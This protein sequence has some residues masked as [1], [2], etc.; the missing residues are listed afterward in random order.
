MY[1]VMLLRGFLL[2]K[3]YLNDGTIFEKRF[4]CVVLV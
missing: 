1:L 4:A 3:T 2:A